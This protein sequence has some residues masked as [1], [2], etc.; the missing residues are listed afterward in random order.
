MSEIE[1]QLSY[2]RELEAKNNYI[3]KWNNDS[4]TITP[5]ATGKKSITID[6]Q[7]ESKTFKPGKIGIIIIGCLLFFI[8]ISVL[9]GTFNTPQAL[10]A[11]IIV[12]MA[13][14]FLYINLRNEVENKRLNYTIT[15][16]REG[17]AYDETLYKWTDIKETAYLDLP[18]DKNGKTFLI[19]LFNN[20]QY[21]TWDVTN[22][23]SK[24]KLASYIAHFK[25]KH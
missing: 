23:Q 7:L 17:I 6:E 15:L 24:S 22:F 9:I 8:G 5:T 21:D 13:F 2:I 25:T 14:V 16:S 11:Y 1:E 12:P 10:G 19:L 3:P 18:I 4:C 20:N